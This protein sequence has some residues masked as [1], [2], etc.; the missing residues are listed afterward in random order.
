MGSTVLKQGRAH[1]IWSI[2]FPS[3]RHDEGGQGFRLGWTCK[4][5]QIDVISHGEVMHDRQCLGGPTSH[6][7]AV[8]ALGSSIGEIFLV[9]NS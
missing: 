6:S 7:R 4:R 3:L 8:E 9:Q 2:L 1:T 5:W